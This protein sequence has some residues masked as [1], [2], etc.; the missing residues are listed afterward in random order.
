[1]GWPLQLNW[2]SLD[3][4]N[5]GSA[6]L[7]SAASA[8]DYFA[9]GSIFRDDDELNWAAPDFTAGK[10]VYQLSGSVPLNGRSKQEITELTA[11][12]DVFLYDLPSPVYLDGVDRVAERKALRVNWRRFN[13]S[14]EVLSACDEITKGTSWKD[15]VAVHVRRG[16][17][18]NMLT[19]GPLEH[20]QR[21]GIIQIFQRYIA[22]D[23]VVGQ[24]RKHIGE[25]G[26]LTVCSEETA[27]AGRLS[28][29]FPD[30]TVAGSNGKFA[31]DSNKA[32]LLDLLLL[33][34]SRAIICPPISY[35]SFCASEVSLAKRLP[36]ILDLRN[37]VSELISI[38]DASSAEDRNSRKAIVYGQAYRNIAPD[39][40]HDY[41]EHL[42]SLGHASDGR[43]MEMLELI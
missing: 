12:Y 40:D 4:A 21:D 5:Y 1:M 28:R 27:I 2:P 31:D 25:F 18:L 19:S 3:D 24:V 10:R 13:F 42:R 33:T 8:S 43:M 16:D 9:R 6:R 37:L 17:I 14:P 36:S 22:F 11:T 35:Y 30:I 26:S 32:A 20:L 38:L 7:L 39:Q 34:R 15:T 23:T 29:T 41:R